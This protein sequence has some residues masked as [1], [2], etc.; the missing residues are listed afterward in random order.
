MHYNIHTLKSIRYLLGRKTSR[1]TKILTNWIAVAHVVNARP[2]LQLR[3]EE[4]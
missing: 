2:F 4:R 1:D 3:R